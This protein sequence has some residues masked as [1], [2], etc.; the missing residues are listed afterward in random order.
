M[1]V[2]VINRTNGYMTTYTPADLRREALRAVKGKGRLST[3]WVCF[4]EN[5]GA[6]LI[7]QYQQPDGWS[8]TVNIAI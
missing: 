4:T 8:A 7:A 6:T 3:H 1:N 2:A 5:A